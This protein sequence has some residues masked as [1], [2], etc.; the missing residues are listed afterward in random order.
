MWGGQKKARGRALNAAAR[1]ASAAPAPS[2]QLS[3]LFPPHL[4]LSPPPSRNFTALGRRDTQAHNFLGACALRRRG[5]LRF[6]LFSSFSSDCPEMAWPP[7]LEGRTHGFAG[8]RT[9]TLR[10]ASEQSSAGSVYERAVEALFIY[11][12]IRRPSRH[13]GKG[14]SL[15]V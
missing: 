7:C 4:S 8:S 1:P 15:L 13:L 9:E 11:L 10:R 6:L 3:F 2:P 12:C 5:G 14:R